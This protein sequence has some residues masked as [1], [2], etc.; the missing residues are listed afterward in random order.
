[1]YDALYA[2]FKGLYPKLRDDFHVLSDL[3]KD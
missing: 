2:E 3:K 1:L